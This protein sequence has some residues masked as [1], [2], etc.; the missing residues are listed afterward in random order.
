M[1]PGVRQPKHLGTL[2]LRGGCR[3][4]LAG[5]R[6]VPAQEEHELSR[7]VVARDRPADRA[8]F[9]RG[10]QPRGIPANAFELERDQR[11]PASST[12][13]TVDATW[14]RAPAAAVREVEAVEGLRR[15]SDAFCP[16]LCA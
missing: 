7:G 9:V 14:E 3:D 1:P 10:Q 16:L 12:G 5:Q 6:A 11:D 4:C 2:T 8:R 15:T 13:R